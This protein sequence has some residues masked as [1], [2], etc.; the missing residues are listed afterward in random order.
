MDDLE[1]KVNQ[2]RNS[3]PNLLKN[4]MVNII[5]NSDPRYPVNKALIEATVVDV[6]QRNKVSGK[7]EVGVSIVG[8]RKMHSINKQYRGIDSTTNI[9][10]F[11]LEDY[12]SE[13]I[14]HLPRVGFIAPP[15]NMLRLG[16]ILISYPQ[17][18]EDASFDGV[19]VDEEIK[20]LIEHGVKHLLGIHHDSL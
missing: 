17:V 7:V 16:D 20:L 10:T 18:V 5:V 12:S 19:T 14:Q 13:N 11:A 6:L 4:Y 9:L 2:D 15:D 8:D 3:L 1:N